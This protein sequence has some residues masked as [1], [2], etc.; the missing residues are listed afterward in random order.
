ME[1]PKE[2]IK[3]F[4]IEGGEELTEKFLKC[5]VLLLTCMFGELNKVS[6]N[7]F[8]TNP[9]NCV[10]LQGYTCQCGLKYT[11]INLQTQADK[12]MIS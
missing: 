6:V 3:R 12:V 8:G 7:E 11:G 4:N 9:L 2:I 10:C 1:R 5:D